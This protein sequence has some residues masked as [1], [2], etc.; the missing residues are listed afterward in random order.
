MDIEVPFPGALASGLSGIHD[1][2]AGS[3]A[4]LVKQMTERSQDTRYIAGALSVG[5]LH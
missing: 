1:A 2:A 4:G 5:L 3:G